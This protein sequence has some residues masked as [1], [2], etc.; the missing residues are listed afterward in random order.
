MESDTYP[1][2]Y[3]ERASAGAV[4]LSRD[5]PTRS[6]MTESSSSEPETKA[7]KPNRLPIV[8]LVGLLLVGAGEVARR[9]MHREFDP[10]VFTATDNRLLES[11]GLILD[12][13]PRLKELLN[14]SVLNLSLPDAL[15]VEL[16]AHSA[17][18][19]ELADEAPHEKKNLPALQLTKFSWTISDRAIETAREDVSLWRAL[20]Q[21]VDY[22]ERAGF[23]FVRSHFDD[24]D[25]NLLHSDLAFEGLARDK[26]GRLVLVKAEQRVNWRPSPK[27]PEPA[28]DVPK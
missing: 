23:K 9:W 5:Q 26:S 3:F 18:I 7:A 24:A 20:F 4:S 27:S 12:L 14:T 28:S 15:G 19:Q 13:T 17:A 16:F 11:E 6:A 2:I 21:S 1:V 10:P 25:T 8:V 22:F